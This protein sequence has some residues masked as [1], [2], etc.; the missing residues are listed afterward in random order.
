[1]EAGGS[2][3]A[4]FRARVKRGMSVGKQ[5]AGA[6]YARFVEQS[7][8]SPA[9]ARFDKARRISRGIAEGVCEIFQRRRFQVRSQILL[10]L[11]K[12]AVAPQHIYQYKPQ[13][14]LFRLFFIE[15][16]RAAFAEQSYHG[17]SGKA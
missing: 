2:G 13:K 8:K 6:V 17:R 9:R 1:M 4:R 3:K 11:N 7:G 15:I 10:Q 16:A 5:G 14:S 12:R